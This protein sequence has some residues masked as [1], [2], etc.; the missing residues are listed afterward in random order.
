MQGGY[1]AAV[2]AAADGAGPSDGQPGRTLAWDS[3]NPNLGTPD[4]AHGAANLGL[5][6]PSGEP[7]SPDNDSKSPKGSRSTNQK[8]RRN[9]RCEGALMI[10]PMMCVGPPINPGSL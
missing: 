2:S 10:W 7:L 4:L 6:G 1:A 8:R 9:G 5:L 3:P